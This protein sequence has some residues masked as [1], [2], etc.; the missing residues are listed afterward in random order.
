MP[1]FSGQPEEYNK[2]IRS[3]EGVIERYQLSS[4]EKYVYLVRQ[5]TGSAK[6]LIENLS[7]ENLDYKSARELL[8]GAF[9]SKLDQQ[10][11]ILDR[12][13]KLKL[14]DNDDPYRWIC[15]TR[16]LKH[17]IEKLKIDSDLMLQYFMWKGLNDSFKSIFVSICN[18]SKPSLEQMMENSFEANKHY[19]EF[20]SASAR[21]KVIQKNVDEKQKITLNLATN[22]NNNNNSLFRIKYISTIIQ[23]HIQGKKKK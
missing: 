19:N 4:Y 13:S 10:Y 9:C 11:S 12:L 1:K 22:N 21:Q 17:H 23:F 20:K 8:D 14:N 7:V 18:T 3:F 5:L 6:L 16:V 15:E 2:F